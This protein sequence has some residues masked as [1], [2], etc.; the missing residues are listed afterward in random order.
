MCNIKYILRLDSICVDG[1]QE[2]FKNYVQ[3]YL[4]PI[5]CGLAFIQLAF[6]LGCSSYDPLI[7]IHNAVQYVMQY[8]INTY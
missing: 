5:F 1:G 6:E 8:G 7:N 4:C 3:V 2:M